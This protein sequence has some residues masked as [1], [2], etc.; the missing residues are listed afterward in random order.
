MHQSLAFYINIFNLQVCTHT[1][2]NK[3]KLDKLDIYKL[4]NDKL[5][6]T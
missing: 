4:D 6:N 2:L 5:Q 3:C 1:L